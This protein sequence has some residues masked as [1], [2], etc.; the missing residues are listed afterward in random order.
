M[1]T[2]RV[3]QQDDV[4]KLLKSIFCVFVACATTL[5]GAIMPAQAD[6]Y[7]W[8]DTSGVIYYSNHP[9]ADLT[10]IIAIIPSQNAAPGSDAEPKAFY[11]AAPGG[12]L[13]DSF[14]IPPD[15]LQELF[16]GQP[17]TTAAASAPSEDA[18]D[19]TTLTMR[20][21]EVE[22]TLQ[23]EVET[24]V[25]WQQQYAQAQSVIKTLEQQ[26]RALNLVL[27]NLEE[28]IDFLRGTV[29]ASDLEVSALKQRIQPGQYVML[30]N[31]V[32]GLQEQVQTIALELQTLN[33]PI[34]SEKVAALSADIHALKIQQQPDYDVSVRLTALE[35]DVQ[36]LAQT[37]AA[38][39]QTAVAVARLEANGQAL[40][41][42]SANHDRRLD[43]QQ[44]QIAALQAELERLKTARMPAENQIVSP[45]AESRTETAAAPSS[46]IRILPRMER[47]RTSLF[48]RFATWLETP[49]PQLLEE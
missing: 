41:N 46:G 7:K 19:L 8:R 45:N 12:Q 48:V 14:T 20:L 16:N 30:A 27:A 17:S 32:T 15:V 9:P 10:S 47:R 3:S 40:S 36:N 26:N 5:F 49:Q 39:A 34:L 35:S 13:A 22:Q 24:R 38:P 43:D 11:L 28:N 42:I 44:V 23:Q 6:I 37:H 2:I 31:S 4:R 21:A 1:Y 29:V 25:Q 18:P 33:A